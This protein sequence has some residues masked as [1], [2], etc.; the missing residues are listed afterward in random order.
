MIF[1]VDF[2]SKW[3]FPVFSFSSKWPHIAWTDLKELRSVSRDSAISAQ[4]CPRHGI[5]VGLV[6]HK[7]LPTSSASAASFLKSSVLREFV[8]GKPSV[9]VA[10]TA[11]TSESVEELLR[12]VT[13]SLFPEVSTFEVSNMEN[14][15]SWLHG[16]RAS[17]RVYHRDGSMQTRRRA[18]TLRCRSHFIATSPSH[19]VLTPGQP[20]P[21]RSL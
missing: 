13:V 9:T 4:G 6:E 3:K 15:L 5:I 14:G 8:D 11:G 19:S 7:L 21:A 2:F 18:A 1:A 17:W 16:V 12:C 20:V 10:R